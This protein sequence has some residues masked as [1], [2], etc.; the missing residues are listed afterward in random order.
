MN[1][2][3]VTWLMAPDAPEGPLTVEDFRRR[4]EWHARA[5][6]RGVGRRFV[7]CPVRQECLEAAL[8]ASLTP[9]ATAGVGG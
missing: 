8:G 5:L 1:E 3:L 7:T 6:C 2:A 9:G 4:P